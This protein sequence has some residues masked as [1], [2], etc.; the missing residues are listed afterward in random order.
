[1]VQPSY[2]FDNPLDSNGYG[3]ADFET[4][5]RNLFYLP[6]NS[7]KPVMGD[8]LYPAE[9]KAII[10]TDTLET[11][12]FIGPKYK[13]VSHREAID[14]VR[15]II[16][17]SDLDKSDIKESI[18]IANNG[19]R[20]IVGYTLPNEVIETPDG[21]TAALSF[22]CTNSYDGFM[23]FLISV[24]AEQT[25]CHNGQIFTAGASTIYK[26]R[27]TGQLNIDR[28]A[29][30]VSKGLE[31]LNEENDKWLAWYHTPCGS[32]TASNLFVDITKADPEEPMKTKSYAYLMD[33]YDTHYRTGNLWG[34]YNALTDWATHS[35]PARDNSCVVN[36][37]S[38][39]VE[40]V[41][42]F[43]TE[44]SRFALAA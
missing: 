37:R 9:K 41:R 7:G 1:M 17:R 32:V 3:D 38:R 34:V 31:V 28:G 44:D 27:H 23:A 40:K 2:L 33:V 20:C 39:K 43:I 36:V 14:K 18:S 22:L 6:F 13:V 4:E 24:G 12:G 5:T 29:R 42:K 15:A 25:A 21:D 30:I 19:S 10:R 16:H 11:L 35:K 8:D 26:S